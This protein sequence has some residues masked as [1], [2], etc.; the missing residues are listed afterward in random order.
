MKISTVL[1]VLAAVLLV[2]A[3]PVPYTTGDSTSFSQVSK[4]SPHHVASPNGSA[5]ASV[6]TSS[7]RKRD[8]KNTLKKRHHSKKED[9]DK[10]DKDKTESST[11]KE[12]TDADPE[13]GDGN[14]DAD[15]E[16]GDGNNDADPEGGDGNN[17]ADA[18]NNNSTG[19]QD[20]DNE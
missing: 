4:R 20:Q 10:N 17:D 15:P 14:S 1:T 18:E 3:A 16:G 12:N 8:A 5:A 11:E 9:K 19:N 6:G 7:L 2:Q 13:G